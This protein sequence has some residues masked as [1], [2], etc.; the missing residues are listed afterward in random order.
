VGDAS[1]KEEKGKRLLETYGRGRW[2]K[3]FRLYI[4]QRTTGN[5]HQSRKALGL[6]IIAR[7][8]YT[9]GGNSD[10]QREEVEGL[11]LSRQRFYKKI[12]SGNPKG[13]DLGKGDVFNAVGGGKATGGGVL[14]RN[15]PA[16][17]CLW[18]GGGLQ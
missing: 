9:S 16:L 7:G 3:V 8:S 2:V 18:R 11:C 17:M 4:Q 13:M 14:E 6:K 5:L 12:L 15:S 1:T 10:R